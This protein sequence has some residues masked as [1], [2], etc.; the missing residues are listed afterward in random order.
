MSRLRRTITLGLLATALSANP[1]LAAIVQVDPST[2]PQGFLVAASDVATPMHLKIANGPERIYS[3]G[4]QVY[5]QH[6]A[7]APGGSTGWHTH[8]GPVIVTIVRG[9]L[10]LYDGD[11][12]TCTGETFA[13]GSGFADEGFG[14]VHI[15]RNEGSTPAEFY[16]TYILPPGSGDAGV[17]TP[18]PEF[19][20]PACPF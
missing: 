8:A 4:S 6:A 3:D 12:R 5:V 16:A 20:N 11:D 15:A 10:T 9:A 13:A 17:K 2:V 19:H 7:I 14:H 1:I 18:L